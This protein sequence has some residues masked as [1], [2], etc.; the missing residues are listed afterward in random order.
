M[1]SSLGWESRL[2]AARRWEGLGRAQAELLEE[3]WK[4]VLIIS[5]IAMKPVIITP[6][7]S[8]G[9]GAV[10]GSLQLSRVRSDHHWMGRHR[11]PR[12]TG[13]EQVGGGAFL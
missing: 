4:A 2:L 7:A 9:P 8:P 5:T 11:V 12:E 10:I 1:L 6:P 13:G 3:L